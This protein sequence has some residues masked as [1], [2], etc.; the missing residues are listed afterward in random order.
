MADNL[1]AEKG[2]SGFEVR[3][4]ISLEVPISKMTRL[5]D[6]RMGISFRGGRGGTFLLEWLSRLPGWVPAWWR[7]GSQDV[8]ID[9]VDLLN[10]VGLVL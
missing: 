8:M 3:H 9:G 6:H 7:G 2:A 4:R 1:K 5:S 10:F